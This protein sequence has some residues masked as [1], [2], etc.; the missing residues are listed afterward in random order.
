MSS[1]L[2]LIVEQSE[3]NEVDYNPN[4]DVVIQALKER[5]G[6]FSIG[7]LSVNGASPLKVVSELEQKYEGTKV[8]GLNQTDKVDLS[9]HKAY[10][11]S[12]NTTNLSQIKEYMNLGVPIFYCNTVL[13]QG[14]LHISDY[15]SGYVE[16]PMASFYAKVFPEPIVISNPSHL[17]LRLGVTINPRA[18]LLCSGVDG[19]GGKIEID[20]GSHVGA[21]ALLNLGKANFKVG[22][23]S[24]I[25]ANFSAHGMR[26]ALT[27]LSSYSMTKGPFK[28]L[29]TLCDQFGDVTIGNDVWIGE[30]VTL[31]ANITIG[32]GAVIGAGSVVTKSVEPYGTYAG[33]PARLIKKR[34]C[35]KKITLLQKMKWWD[36]EYEKLFKSRHYFSKN[37]EKMPHGEFEDLIFPLIGEKK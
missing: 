37:I 20:R 28:W 14:G 24:L 6:S 15:L 21:D 27:H 25:S 18:I 2:H 17:T 19:E 35:D 16:N 33:N 26:H 8:Y 31:L 7:V 13:V 12:K 30:R 11:P 22:K 34:F 1:L 4:I 3:T 5:G 9:E 10:F 23:F 36:Y 32:D 29:G